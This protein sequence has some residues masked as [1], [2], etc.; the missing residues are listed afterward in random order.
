M[1]Y[2]K[3]LY[4]NI[5][6]RVQALQ[7]KI[8][9]ESKITD[10]K[11]TYYKIMNSNCHIEKEIYPAPG[12]APSEVTHYT[13]RD[14]ETGESNRFFKITVKGITD[15]SQDTLKKARDLIKTQKAGEDYFKYFPE[16]A[17][18]PEEASKK[19][20]LYLKNDLYESD[21]EVSY[22]DPALNKLF[23]LISS[24]NRLQAV[25]FPST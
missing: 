5:F 6:I 24:S 12:G 23:A 25:R 17:I 15:L 2:S 8:K 4:H 22:N 9:N 21:Y 14:F 19:M 10:A 20:T 7:E 13:R 3:D 18:N 11:S 16:S 1:I